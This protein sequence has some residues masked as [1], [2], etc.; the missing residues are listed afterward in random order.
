MYDPDIPEHLRGDENIVI[1]DFDGQPIIMDEGTEGLI[2]LP[3]GVIH[4]SDLR[5]V[6]RFKGISDHVAEHLLDVLTAMHTTQG[7]TMENLTRGAI[8]RALVGRGTN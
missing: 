5:V 8:L 4:T 7:T 2:G 6:V 3:I 1:A